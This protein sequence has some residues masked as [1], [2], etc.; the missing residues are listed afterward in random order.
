VVA[1]RLGLGLG[2]QLW[3][4][5]PAGPAAF[6]VAGIGN[7]EFTTC[8]LDLADGATL[9]GA[10]EVN[11]VMVKVRP[12]ADASTVRR[13]L[14]DAVHDHGGTLLPLSQAAAQ[15]R[16]A[17]QQAWLSM[18]L[19]IGITGLVAGLGVVN[20]MLAAVAGRRQ[21]IGLLRAVGATRRQITRLILAEMAL[22]GAV[23]AWLGT[24]LGWA[25]T[26]LF[27]TLARN[28]LGLSGGGADSPAAWLPL[29]AASAA[30]LLLWPLLAMLGGLA[31]AWRAGRMPPVE[32][33]AA[34]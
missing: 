11:A 3:L 28:Y 34:L 8:L 18:S 21:E 17:F 13:V 5:T 27:L 7:S 15:L 32:A 25:V 19:L 22:L 10:N 16:L 30:G 14:L 23:A 26:L 29:L 20:T 2:D 4:D 9:L 24:A 31:P 1:R 33:L 6:R 12:G